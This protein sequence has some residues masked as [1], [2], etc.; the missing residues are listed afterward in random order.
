MN[1][2]TVTEEM[3]AKAAYYALVET[4]DREIGKIVDEMVAQQL[5]ENTLIIYTS[6]HGDQLG[7]RDLWFKQ[8][9]YDHSAKVPLI[10]NW[11]K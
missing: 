8:T 2:M 9:F 5:S 4:M 6:D 11:P 1:A 3:R 10:L 7:E